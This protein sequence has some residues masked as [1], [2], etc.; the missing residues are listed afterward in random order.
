MFYGDAFG[1]FASAFNQDLS[2][3]DVSSVTNMHVRTPKC[4]C[5]ECLYCTSSALVL[6]LQLAQPAPY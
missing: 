5:L 2:G 1:F 4:H 6:S 3:W